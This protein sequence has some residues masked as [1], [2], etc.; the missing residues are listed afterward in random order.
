MIQKLGLIVLLAITSLQAL[1]ITVTPSKS[2]TIS[3]H[4]AE[5]FRNILMKRHINID[6][7]EAKKVLKQNRV[8]A[9]YFYKTYG[10]EGKIEEL[11]IVFEEKLTEELIKKEVEKVTINDDVLLS[12]YKD[13]KDEYYKNKEIEFKIYNFKT[14]DAA[15]DFYKHCNND[16]A[17]CASLSREQNISIVH[18]TLP[19]NNF[20]PQLQNLLVDNTRSH[21]IVAPQKFFKNYIILEVVKISDDGIMPYDEVKDIVK[22]D[23]QNKIKYETKK[24]LIEKLLPTS[25]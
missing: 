4:E 14:F 8:F 22:T 2:S 24:K 1:D 19:L 12:F 25:E 17:K 11:R 7:Q 6:P 13:N 20:N 21:Y 23:L 3:S 16:S 10:I 9:D 5:Y 18:K 15:Y